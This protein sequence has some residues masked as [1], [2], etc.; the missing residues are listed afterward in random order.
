[1]RVR[2]KDLVLR[3]DGTH[4]RL[5]QRSEESSIR[6]VESRGIAEVFEAIF[7]SRRNDRDWAEAIV[8]SC[9]SEIGT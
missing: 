6:G 2:T 3:G 5:Q 9:M 8:L 7:D 4:R 1:V